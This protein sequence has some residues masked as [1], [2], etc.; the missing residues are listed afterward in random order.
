[1]MRSSNFPSAVGN[2]SRG[3]VGSMNTVGPCWARP[4]SPQ[5]TFGQVPLL[6][7]QNALRR[8]WQRWGLPGCL[9]V[10]NGVPWGNSNDLPTPFALWV[11]GLGIDWHWNDP[12]CPQQ[13]PKVE[14]SQGTAKRWAEPRR[15]DSVNELQRR[16]DEADRIQRE[17]YPYVSGQ[18]RLT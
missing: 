6:A 16:L 7:V 13:N 2:R 9:R 15:C 18:S 12:H 5:A 14:R 1:W 11:W 17:E 4:F 3:C 8:Q 10:D